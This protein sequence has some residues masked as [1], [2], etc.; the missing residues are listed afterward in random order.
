MVNGSVS[1]V[2]NSLSGP[3]VPSLGDSYF[4]TLSAITA[5]Q[6]WPS[7][8][9]CRC[10]MGLDEEPWYLRS[11]GIFAFVDSTQKKL[12]KFMKKSKILSEKINKAHFFKIKG[13]TLPFS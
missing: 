9:S 11:E 1:S 6:S 13:L 8:G 10:S 2:N 4:T 3:V 12:F 5:G 7:S